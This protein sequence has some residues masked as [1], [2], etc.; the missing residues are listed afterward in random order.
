ME[1]GTSANLG[2][3][4]AQLVGIAAMAVGIG[5]RK[6]DAKKEPVQAGGKRLKPGEIR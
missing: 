2:V 1:F 6:L 3:E 4:E 5:W